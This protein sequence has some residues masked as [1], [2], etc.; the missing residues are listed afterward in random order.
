MSEG[1][2]SMGNRHSIESE[3]L[4]FALGGL[5]D[6]RERHIA[7][8]SQKDLRQTGTS[9]AEVGYWLWVID[10]HLQDAAGFGPG[11]KQRRGT[12]EGR[13]VLGMRYVRDRQAHQL[14]QATSSD[15]RMLFGGGRPGSPMRF[16]P[17]HIAEF[18]IWR[19]LE[20]L[21]EPDDGRTSTPFYLQLRDAYRDL[22]AGR[23]TYRPIDKAIDWTRAEVD[24]ATQP[25]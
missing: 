20:D 6:A 23:S 1:P 2:Q 9:A 19:D 21:R 13:Y 17:F 22:F 18:A 15:D 12:G 14:V 16:P 5:R 3:D 25:S 11:Y 4:T 8:F 7:A 24:A 10:E